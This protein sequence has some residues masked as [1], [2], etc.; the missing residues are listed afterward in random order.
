MKLGF[1]VRRP[2]ALD[3]S[4]DSGAH[5]LQS[6]WGLQDRKLPNPT[7]SHQHNAGLCCG[8]A[9]VAEHLGRLRRGHGGAAAV[10]QASLRGEIA[11]ASLCQLGQQRSLHRARFRQRIVQRAPAQRPHIVFR[12]KLT[13]RLVMYHVTSSAAVLKKNR[14]MIGRAGAV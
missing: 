13:P 10:D 6:V 12:G 9:G 8:A 4:A 2:S 7:C 11:A 3:E 1:R 5:F 14:L